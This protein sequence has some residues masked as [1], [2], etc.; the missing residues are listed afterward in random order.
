MDWRAFGACADSDPELFFPSGTSRNAVL[1]A[2]Q[3]KLICRACSVQEKCRDYA[4]ATEQ[5]SGVWGGLSERELKALRRRPLAR[6][7]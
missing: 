4:V 2:E 3:A 6:G 1:Q 7:A 5:D